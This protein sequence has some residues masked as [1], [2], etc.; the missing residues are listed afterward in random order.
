M[1]IKCPICKK[2]F[3]IANYSMKYKPIVLYCIQC[4]TESVHQNLED[5]RKYVEELNRKNE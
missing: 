3:I 4:D 1:D 5:V 2:D